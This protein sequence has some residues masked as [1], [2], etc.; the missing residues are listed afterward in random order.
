MP[1]KLKREVEPRP[2]LPTAAELMQYI[3]ATPG[4]IGKGDIARAFGIKGA[5]K[6]SLKKMLKDLSGSGQV[7][8]QKRNFAST[9]RLPPVGVVEI[10][11]EVSDVKKD[12]TGKTTIIIKSDDAFSNV[13]VILK[14]SDQQ[15][16]AG[17]TITIKGICTGFLSD[18]VV[19]EAIIIK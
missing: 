3:T 13:F 7:S 16:Q 9:T 4:A 12:Q 1:K 2:G 6:I 14:Q 5:D 11:G 15:P 19:N 10:T 8:R 17:A 18:V